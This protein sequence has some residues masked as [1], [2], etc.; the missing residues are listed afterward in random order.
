[1]EDITLSNTQGHDNRCTY[2]HYPYLTQEEFAE[3][4]HLLDS[5]Y[6]RATLGPTRKRWRLNVHTALNMSFTTG[7]DFITFLQITRP[8]HDSSL[9]VDD[10]LASQMDNICLDQGIREHEDAGDNSM[11]EADAMMVEM[12]DADKVSHC[13]AFPL[14]LPLYLNFAF[15]CIPTPALFYCCIHRNDDIWCSTLLI[16]SNLQHVVPRQAARPCRFV[17]HHSYVVYEVHL[18]PTYRAPCLWFTLHNL[19]PHEPA[20]DIETVFRHLVP[21][22]F[23]ESLRSP[24]GI[25][26]ISADVGGCP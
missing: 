13:Q 12:E 16:K 20:L 5:K 7:S 11:T 8:L 19:P 14:Y 3:A 18:H 25:G 15:D 22:Q 1:M 2:Q 10:E 21:D 26:G 6:C 9:V 23:K 17:G 24:G 4:C